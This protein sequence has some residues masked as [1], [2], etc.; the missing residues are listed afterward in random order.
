VLVGAN[1][2][3]AT[4]ERRTTA[5]IARVL[6]PHPHQGAEQALE[7]PALEKHDFASLRSVV[8]R[9]EVFNGDG[10]S[11]VSGAYRDHHRFPVGTWCQ[12]AR[13][14]ADDC[15]ITFSEQVDVG[16]TSGVVA[17]CRC[18]PIADCRQHRRLDPIELLA[19]LADVRPDQW[20]TITV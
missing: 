9:N 3:T 4:K 15:D 7:W 2:V 6:D 11:W 17:G 10:T 14:E 12:V 18:V 20:S 13:V 1:A 16:S 5:F 19:M 8:P